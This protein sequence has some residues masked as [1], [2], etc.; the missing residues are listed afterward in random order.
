MKYEKPV[1]VAVAAVKAI[2]GTGG[3]IKPI[4]IHA[5]QLNVEFPRPSARMRRMSKSALGSS[6]S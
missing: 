5:D 6:L 1:V 2:Q 3:T 4:A